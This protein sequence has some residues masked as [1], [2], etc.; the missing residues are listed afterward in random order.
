MLDLRLLIGY[1]VVI[2]LL[3]FSAIV[4]EI[5]TL[6]ERGV[7]S[8]SNFFS[9]FTIQSNILVVVTLLLS[10]LAAAAGDRDRFTT[11]R[12]AVTVYILVVGIGFSLLLS[13]LQGVD[14]TAVP[15]DNTVLH[16]IVPVA[17]LVDYLLDR[18]RRRLSFR[19]S[20]LW[21]VYPVAYAAYS[22][23]RGALVDWYPYPFLDPATNGAGAVAITIL[24]LIVLGIGLIWVITR[25][26]GRGATGAAAGAPPA[27]LRTH[28][29]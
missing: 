4:T 5:A 19:A 3:G 18:P 12:A 25:L 9:F 16:Y 28:S 23:I 2:A 26:S 14:L 13:N 29:T 24:G 20:L 27:D 8:P 22:L 21:L 6:V 11:L 1:R 7:F 10:A 17:M 15:W